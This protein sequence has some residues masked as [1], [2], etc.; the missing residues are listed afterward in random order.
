MTIGDIFQG[1][2][3]LFTVPAKNILNTLKT[4]SNNKNYALLQQ[5]LNDLYYPDKTISK[6]G[7]EITNITADYADFLTEEVIDMVNSVNANDYTYK[8]NPTQHKQIKPETIQKSIND[9]R[10]II[11]Q[12]KAAPDKINGLQKMIATLTG[13][14][15]A[16]QRTLNLIKQDIKA[17]GFITSTENERHPFSMAL[18]LY[19]EL[20]EYINILKISPTTEIAGKSLEH[21]LSRLSINGPKWETK[22]VNDLIEGAWTGPTTQRRAAKHSAYDGLYIS[23]ISLDSENKMN[24]SSFIESYNSKGINIKTTYDAGQ[25]KQIKMDVNLKINDGNNSNFRIS[26]KNWTRSY[27]SLG[28]TYILNALDRTIGPNLTIGYTLTMLS[29]NGNILQRA[30]DLAKLSILA[31]I[32]TGFSQTE[33][34]ADTLIINIRSKPEI[35][36]INPYTI[37]ENYFLKQEAG[38]SIKNYNESNI[39]TTAHKILRSMKYVQSPGRTNFYKSGMLSLLASYKVSV[40][41]NASSF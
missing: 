22:I 19:Q 1:N 31:D 30:H 28:E 10:N 9:L 34:Y 18:R 11:N 20:N 36:V 37:I 32:I 29:N 3:A 7:Q 17:G 4:R 12:I 16:A 38:V 35:R 27:N 33:G 14:V 8:Y 15:G 39:Q 6:A 40:M 13:K 24:V 26:A 23:Q 2:G 25:S 21:S 41:L 5:Q